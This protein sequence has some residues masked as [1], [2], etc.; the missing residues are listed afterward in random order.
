MCRFLPA[1]LQTQLQVQ[2][3]PM[4]LHVKDQTQSEHKIQL[5]STEIKG[6]QRL[7]GA[8]LQEKEN[9]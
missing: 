1:V 4:G 9:T 7:D 3:V 5:V 6:N 8:A 2:L